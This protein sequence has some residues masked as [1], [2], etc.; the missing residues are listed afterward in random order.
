MKTIIFGAGFWGCNYIKEL[1]HNVVAVIE[2]DKQKAEF[3]TQTFNIPTYPAIPTHINFDAAII[4]TPP[5]SHIQLAKGLLAEG[6]Y[7]LIEKPFATSV[8]EALQLYKWRDKCMAGM[9]YLYHPEVERL[10]EVIKTVPLNHAFSRR[11]NDGP[12]RSWQNSM[13]DLAAHDVSIF[14]YI[15]GQTPHA[16]EAIST[17]TR[18]WAILRMVYVAIETLTYVSW[19]GGPKIRQVELVPQEGNERIIFDDV[20]TV[21]AV[22]PMRRMLDAFMSGKWDERCSFD[23]GIEVVNVLEKAQRLI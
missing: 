19:R 3:V 15:F 23:A 13:W 11:T 22:T 18:D 2:T 4:V 17:P 5:D 9:I 7:V 10:K 14:N 20:K 21:L 12:I 16:V 6:H 1:S 8:E